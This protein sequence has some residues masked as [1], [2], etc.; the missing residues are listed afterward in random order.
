MNRTACWLALGLSL[1]AWLGVHTAQ[2]EGA[3]DGVVFARRA[4]VLR[5]QHDT[6]AHR[7]LPCVSCHEPRNLASDDRTPREAQC[8]PCHA[9]RIERSQP[10]VERC[11]FCHRDFDPAHAR[12]PEPTTRLISRLKFA[13]AR[14]AS[15]DC[16][17]CHVAAD[18]AG[19][20]P[21][22][23]SMQTCLDCHQ[24]SRALPCNGCHITLPS[25]RLRVN[26][27]D[28]KL[29]PRGNLLGMAHDADFAVR[30]RWLA[31]DE[32]AVCASCHVES[33]C[34]ACHDGPR[35]P[36]SLHPNDYLLLHAQDSQRNAQRCT[37]C[38]ASSTF[39]LPCHAR[40]GI[41]QLS[42]PDVKSPKRFHPAASQWIRGPVLHAREA[43][44]SL[45]SCVS[46]HAERDCVDCHG[47]R[48]MGVGLHSP[49][50]Q[51]FKANCARELAQGP[52]A[53]L[54]CHRTSDPVLAA[55]R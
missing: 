23:P 43:E 27:P 48:G 18:A 44:R 4:H 41:A 25:G 52:R 40:L 20:E 47:A 14:H 45:A 50:P 30:H 6:P 28:G 37:S 36:R 22:L 7:A 8:A 11:G 51:G 33:E 39:C 17:S 2:G 29:V 34:E 54:L 21:S 46:C 53:C 10:S 38:H 42:A 13:H 15:V 24:K 26:F 5:M 55:C 32:G 31:A 35:K 19:L 9:E 16:R 3:A 1:S 49:H 12:A